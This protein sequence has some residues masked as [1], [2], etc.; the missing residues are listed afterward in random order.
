MWE[1][2]RGSPVSLKDSASC[3][4]VV[5]VVLMGKERTLVCIE[6]AIEPWEELLGAVVLFRLVWAEA[7]AYVRLR[8]P[9]CRTTGTYDLLVIVW[10]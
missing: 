1:L 3:E 10:I 7:I 6:H 9:V 8:V 4:H 5:F 2:K